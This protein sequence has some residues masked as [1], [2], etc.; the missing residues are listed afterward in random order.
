MCLSDGFM[1]SNNR[2]SWAWK[3]PG[4]PYWNQNGRSLAW[5]SEQLPV[6]HLEAQLG[7]QAEGRGCWSAWALWVPRSTEIHSSDSTLTQTRNLPSYLF[8]ENRVCS[9]PCSCL[10]ANFRWSDKSVVWNISWQRG[11]FSPP[12]PELSLS[13][14]VFFL[15]LSAPV[16]Q[17][18]CLVREW[19][20]PVL[21]SSLPS[22][23]LGSLEQI[24]ELLSFLINK[25][26]K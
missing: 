15:S 13:L 22:C 14:S 8:P 24:M 11:Y 10:A 7:P 4:L 23:M 17:Y 1:C 19:R 20:Y 26:E 3:R 6:I 9:G 12:L 2:G 25:T 5:L 21:K 18:K 16:S